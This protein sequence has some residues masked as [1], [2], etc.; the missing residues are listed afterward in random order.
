[1]ILME[2]KSKNISLKAILIIIAIGI[3]VIIFQNAGIIPTNQ[4]VRVI[5]SVDAYVSGSVDVDNTVDINIHEINGHRDV[6][7][8][9]PR[10]G[11]KNKYYVLPVSTE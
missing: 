1:M 10:R 11:E 6:F 8:N 3:W 4:N 2:T 5:N 9:N 7:F